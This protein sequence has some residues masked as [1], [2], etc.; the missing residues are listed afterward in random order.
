MH[1][2]L[3]HVDGCLPVTAIK[4]LELGGAKLILQGQS[5]FTRVV[6]EANGKLLAELKTFQR[7]N[8]HGFVILNHERQSKGEEH[9]EILVWGGDS[10]RLVDVL[11]SRS[12]PS[13]G[14]E[15]SLYAA[16][17]EYLAPDWILAGCA[18]EPVGKARK[19]YGVTAHNAVLGF[20]VT[21]A[22]HSKYPKHIHIK[23]PVAGVK[24]LLYSANAVSLSAFQVL[25]AAGTVFGEVIVWSCFLDETNDSSEAV[26]SIH[27]FFTGHEG[28]VFG[29]QI[30]QQIALPGRSS[31]RCLA[32][33]SDDRTVRIWDISD[34]EHVS[35]N[36]PSAYSTDGFELR[37]TGF[38]AASAVKD[39]ELGSE[40]CI[41]SAFGHKA[42]IW[43]VHFIH[44]QAENQNK[45]SLVSSGEDATCVV[46]DFS[47]YSSLTPNT[48]FELNGVASYH[49][50]AGKHIWALDSHSTETESVIYTGGADGGLKSFRIVIKQSGAITLPNRNN[51]VNTSIDSEGREAALDKSIKSFAFVSQDRFLSTTHGGEIQICRLVHGTKP[52]ILKETLSV[53]EDLRSFC[54][55]AKFALCDL[56]V[57][58]GRRGAIRLYNDKT[59]EITLLADTGR[60]SHGVFALGCDL[61]A[62]RLPVALYFL[63]TYPN[64]DRA[65]LFKATLSQDMGAEVHITQIALPHLRHFSIT[66]A[67]LVYDNRYLALG[68]SYGYVRIYPVANAEDP[69]EALWHDIFHSRGSISQIG[70]CSLLFDKPGEL[71]AYFFTC[72]R[73]GTYCIHEIQP[74]ENTRDTISVKTVHRSWPSYAFNIQGAYTDKMSQHL[75]IYGFSGKDFL[76]WNETQ[77]TEVARISCG[78]SHRQWVFQPSMEPNGSAWFLWFQVQFNAVQ[79]Q[80]DAVRTLKPGGHGREIKALS[81]SLTSEMGP[82][83]V[84]GGEDTI[85]RLF[86]LD[87]S[88]LKP[89][90]TMKFHQT[91]LQEVGWS[92]NGRYL[93]TSGGM[94]EFHVWRIR[95]IPYFGA[96]I[97]LESSSPM[98]DPTSELRV[99]SFDVLDVNE[100]NMET[101]FLICLT[102]S[103]S[104]LKIFHYSSSADGG[105]FTLLARG[106][107]T[108]N[109]LT[110]A[111][112]MH[113]GSSLGLVT[114]ATDGHFT[115]WNLTPVIEPY[116]TISSALCP[117]QSMDRI[118]APSENITCE[119]RFQIHSNSI[120]CLEIAEI[121]TSVSLIV[122]GG[123]DN[124]LTFSLL[125]IEPWSTESSSEA[126]T[127]RI[128]DAHAACISTLKVL[129]N[130]ESEEGE[131]MRLT[132]ASSGNDQ[133]VKIWRV[134]V[135]PQND[136]SEAIWVANE[137]N[138]YTGVADLSSLDF[139]SDE[140]A[141]PKLL[142]G[143]VGMELFD[144]RQH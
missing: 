65:D 41:A 28:S 39:D 9:V 6:D 130:R 83:F 20:Y 10:L 110:Q 5:L 81:A 17:A 132:V 68:S 64:F 58:V 19:A 4:I 98:D 91:G 142:V 51:I 113:R 21:G 12:D 123:D 92:K 46:W 79:I 15:V 137:V 37:S 3:E 84:T 70:P 80:A 106:T 117:K 102:Y 72:G 114:A 101:A 82:I 141:T 23:Q 111:R 40:S 57:F 62:S 56:V 69:Q 119:N 90:R 35:R 7:N 25:V 144:I 49:L 129:E 54:F 126:Y 104:K 138:K 139:I 127:V 121:S 133:Q 115:F 108:S 16:S 120:K 143:G 1:S 105:R 103:N 94:E 38:G 87:G 107:Y 11:C 14:L 71:Q 76:V 73:D 75:I 128:P 36:D 27:H 53:Q 78:G 32:S 42:R 122:A 99:T 45:L 89:L 100:S 55:M 140:K 85:L 48:K 8:I 18:A 60:L 112:F 61:N 2:S 31:G 13:G 77:Q 44:T 93:F 24:T 59:K 30:S 136:S 125:R 86:S 88:Q 97:N 118:S 33:C 22:G 134:E 131:T 116:Y 95:S 124:A 26:G 34:C 135:N 96:A 29:V 74:Q 47:W 67:S 43:N 109:C 52:H 50:H 66:C 63:V